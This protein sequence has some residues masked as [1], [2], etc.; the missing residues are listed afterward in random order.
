MQLNVQKEELNRKGE[1]ILHLEK[2][3][4]VKESLYG[5]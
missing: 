2:Q 1:E 3:I 5:K 4:E